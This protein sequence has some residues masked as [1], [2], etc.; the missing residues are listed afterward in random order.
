MKMNSL[1]LI[2]LLTITLV[3]ISCSKDCDTKITTCNET[4]PT[5]E[6]C[7]AAFQRW[8]YNDDKKKCEQIGYSGCSEKG[9]ATLEDCQ[10]CECN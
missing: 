1:K 6:L 9:F 3:I 5:D 4:P 2:L 10:E 8:F 7:Q